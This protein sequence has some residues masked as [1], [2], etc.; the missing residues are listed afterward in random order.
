MSSYGYSAQNTENQ[1]INIDN[2]NIIIN[3]SYW[4]QDGD[5]TCNILYNSGIENEQKYIQ[6]DDSISFN[7]S[8][9]VWNSSYNLNI[10][11]GIIQDV[12]M[13]TGELTISFWKKNTS[14]PSNSDTDILIANGGNVYLKITSTP[15][16]NNKIYCVI[17]DGNG[18]TQN[19]TASTI[20]INF[21]KFN[22]FVYKL[23][24][25]TNSY[26][27]KVFVNGTQV[28]TTSISNIQ[29]ATVD[30]NTIFTFG[31]H[32]SEY[33]DIRIWKHDIAYITPIPVLYYQIYST[34]VSTII[35]QSTNNYNGTITG[36][37][38]NEPAFIY[39][40][41]IVS[42]LSG[43]S[44]SYINISSSV[45]SKLK[46][47]DGFTISYWKYHQSS[48]DN[49]VSEMYTDTNFLKI[50]PSKVSIL[51]TELNN[52]FSFELATWYNIT[53]SCIYNTNSTLE[54]CLYVNGK[55]VSQTVN[56]ING[57][58]DSNISYLRLGSNGTR[59]QEIKFYDKQLSY[60]QVLERHLT[61]LKYG[62]QEHKTQYQ[63]FKF[64]GTLSN[65]ITNKTIP[66][67]F[68][69]PG[70][71]ANIAMWWRF[72]TTS[73]NNY[74][75]LSGLNGTSSG[76]NVVSGIQSAKAGSS[77]T[78]STV[79]TNGTLFNET[80]TQFA[81]SFW[82]KGDTFQITGL[83]MIIKLENN[84]LSFA[85]KIDD[86]E[87]P[88]ITA[89]V[90]NYQD[91]STWHFYTF[92]FNDGI[93]IKIFDN[94]ILLAQAR[95][96]HSKR[97]SSSETS[98]V[99]TP[100]LIQDFRIY[101]SE[102]DHRS[103]ANSMQNVNGSSNTSLYVRYDF[104]TNYEES[105]NTKYLNVID[106]SFDLD[107]R[108]SS[109]TPSIVDGYSG[110]KALSFSNNAQLKLDKPSSITD[111]L[112]KIS[113]GMTISFWSK[114]YM[115]IAFTDTSTNSALLK[116]NLTNSVMR[117]DIGGA[118]VQCNV[119]DTEWHNWV[120][121]YNISRNGTI[122]T[123]LI[124]YMDGV[125]VKDT[126]DED[127]LIFLNSYQENIEFTVGGDSVSNGIIEDLR[128]YSTGLSFHEVQE[129]FYEFNEFKDNFKELFIWYRFYN[130]NNIASINS[131]Y[132]AVI[133][134]SGITQ[135]REGRHYIYKWSSNATGKLTLTDNTHQV[136]S[137]TISLDSNGSYTSNADIVLTRGRKHTITYPSAKPIKISGTGVW[138]EALDEFW[139]EY[140]NNTVSINLPYI[141][142]TYNTL[143]Y[144]CENDQSMGVNAISLLEPE[145]SIYSALQ[146]MV[147]NNMTIAY[148]CKTASKIDINLEN[149]PI[150][151]IQTGNDSAVFRIGIGTGE[152]VGKETIS[153][154]TD[155]DWHHW[156]FILDD[157]TVSTP[158]T[159]ILK[160]YRDAVLV[161]QDTIVEFE[162]FSSIVYSEILN[163]YIGTPNCTLKDFRIY[164][165]HLSE[166]DIYLLCNYHSFDQGLGIN[167]ID[168]LHNPYA[169]H[170]STA[171]KNTQIE[172]PSN[173]LNLCK[174]SIQS[175]ITV[176]IY[177]KSS[178]FEFKFEI[179]TDLLLHVNSTTST[180]LIGT[181]KCT[182]FDNSLN[183]G[184]NKWYR[185]QVSV[186][187]YNQYIQLDSS[188]V[189]TNNVEL[190]RNISNQF[191]TSVIF[192]KSA[193]AK[194]SLIKNCIVDNFKISGPNN[195][196]LLD[197]HFDTLDNSTIVN[198]SSSH[199]NATINE[200]ID[201]NVNLSTTSYS[202]GF[203]L[204]AGASGLSATIVTNDGK[205]DLLLSMQSVQMTLAFWKNDLDVYKGSTD[206]LCYND[207]NEII[208]IVAPNET[209]SVEFHVSNED[210]TTIVKSED[211]KILPNTWYFYT[212]VINF[213][214]LSTTVSV[215]IDA[216]LVSEKVLNGYV[217]F[218]GLTPTGTSLGG[219]P[220]KNESTSPS[221]IEDFRIY[222]TALEV[223]EIYR[224][225]FVNNVVTTT[226][227]NVLFR[228]QDLDN[229]KNLGRL[230]DNIKV[231]KYDTSGTVINNAL[232]TYYSGNNYHQY[233]FNNKSIYWKN[234]TGNEYLEMDGERLIEDFNNTNRIVVMFKQKMNGMRRGMSNNFFTI[235]DYDDNQRV[236]MSILIPDNEQYM[237]VNIGEH[238]LKLNISSN[239]D[240]N[241]W[242][243]WI[244]SINTKN[245]YTYVKIYKDGNP[246]PG[247]RKTFVNTSGNPLQ[248]LPGDR[249][250]ARIGP[251]SSEVYI[252][253][254]RIYNRLITYSDIPLVSNPAVHVSDQ[255][256]YLS[257]NDYTYDLNTVFSGV[258]ISY[259]I[260]SDPLNSAR[261]DNG[262][263]AKIFGNY[264]GQTYDVVFKAYNREGFSLWTVTVEEVNAPPI[265][266]SLPEASATLEIQGDISE[267]GTEGTEQY[268]NFVS[269]IEND[270][271]TALDY[272]AENITIDNITSGSIL[273][274]F[275]VK[276]HPKKKDISPAQ[277]IAS[278]SEEGSPANLRFKNGK[279]TRR[280]NMRIPPGI[281]KQ[282]I[283]PNTIFL[284]LENDKP[285]IF[286]LT[287][288]FSGINVNYQVRD[289][290]YDN[291]IIDKKEQTM[292]I[293]SGFRDDDYIIT[294]R[295]INPSSIKTLLFNITELPQADPVAKDPIN[296][297][298]GDESETVDILEFFIGQSLNQ[299]EIE[300]NPHNNV[301]LVESSV[302]KQIYRIQG[303]FRNDTYEVKFK[304]TQTGVSYPK[305][306]TW[307]LNVY[308]LPPI[309]TK[310]IPDIGSLVL[311]T[312]QNVEYD[313]T[314]VFSGVSMVYEFGCN[315]YGATIT[316]TT[317]SIN[318]NSRGVS[319]PIQVIGKND[320]KTLYWNIN[321]SESMPPPPTTIELNKQI[322]LSTDTYSF[323]LSD[324]FDGT[325]LEYDISQYYRNPTE[326]PPYILPPEHE[327]L[328]NNPPWAR[329]HGSNWDRTF[330]P[331]TSQNSVG[332][333]ELTE[334]NIAERIQKIGGSEVPI[335]FIY[336]DKKATATIPM[337]GGSNWTIC[338]CVKYNGNNKGT[339]ITGNDLIIGHWN[340]N[341]GVVQVGNNFI[342]NVASIGTDTDWLVVCVRTNGT[343]PNNVLLDNS[344]SGTAT[345][346]TTVDKLYINQN[347]SSDWALSDIMIWD[348]ELNSADMSSISNIFVDYLKGKSKILREDKRTLN[349]A[350]IY[351]NVSIDTSSNIVSVSGYYR[352]VSY[353]VYITAKNIKDETTWTLT[354]T[355]LP[356]PPPV[357]IS[358]KTLNLTTVDETFAITNVVSG[359]NI[360]YTI[361]D[362]TTAIEGV[363]YSVIDNIIT[364]TPSYNDTSYSLVVEGS[365]MTSSKIVTFDITETDPQPPQVM[366][367][368]FYLIE[369]DNQLIENIFDNV[370]SANI[371]DNNDIT[372]NN[373]QITVNKA[374]IPFYSVSVES[375]NE[376]GTKQQK[377]NFIEPI[378]NTTLVPGLNTPSFTIYIDSDY[379]DF[380]LSD[381]KIAE[382]YNI[383]YNPYESENNLE[384]VD[385]IL[386]IKD[387]RRGVYDIL[388]KLD[389]YLYVL[390]VN[391]RIQVNLEDR[392]IVNL[393]FD[394]F[395][396]NNTVIPNI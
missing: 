218:K 167:R 26:K 33:Q 175:V 312:G 143:Y 68:I 121:I 369:T 286:D 187:Q 201:P 254:F 342:T 247:G 101:I 344:S 265:Q 105:V 179:D 52:P 225:Y 222:N 205:Q 348:S 109:G 158:G 124:I 170:F 115:N 102:L 119:P 171:G 134:G 24:Y 67:S 21:N 83:D 352:G 289:N 276:P 386:T 61:V 373:N 264:R 185:V 328:I 11:T 51:D 209:G 346:S 231:I 339:I 217:P 106:N 381:L 194:L 271:T 273:V 91:N 321:V 338:T 34:D 190:S 317:M 182:I 371:V 378:Y 178:N 395:T 110:Y 260:H 116:I 256:V 226:D 380:N 246:L 221:Y 345:G 54:I 94:N 153:L 230:L 291:V 211:N 31:S 149:N 304:A 128:I 14:T 311:S 310:L 191:Y 75:S 172:I 306:A 324:I 258:N 314:T 97:V 237:V 302:N 280:A 285:N 40:E 161:N 144:Y 17:G 71:Q 195:R 181:D 288:Y 127:N 229:I 130:N 16:D 7:N 307:T 274:D 183:L 77:G 379:A 120:F 27:L 358:D 292:S 142:Y 150:I 382:T 296:M 356:P 15:Y 162:G 180:F 35:D 227:A 65:Y 235:K 25:T 361:K 393:Q 316:D 224:L 335:N 284:T 337:P 320:S 20:G 283:D 359:Y 383:V 257:G 47:T 262:H 103:I 72:D 329:F 166:N 253:D 13:N 137:Y 299:F 207:T 69:Y 80:F 232:G 303:A 372:Y 293:E 357:S 184:I 322:T 163:W 4:F 365:N 351:N 70:E 343:T 279:Y 122:G 118:T 23:T 240:Y 203:S 241:T 327:V 168:G 30:T 44:N 57:L 112:N 19:L 81:I 85:V 5:N 58:S 136:L 210:S 330:L 233:R 309:P 78:I 391:E 100:T 177:P 138:G 155:N 10:D 160:T 364:L 117:F 8:K 300:L 6:V 156:A 132:G 259:D 55:K 394:S 267:V 193:I 244:F 186:I 251:F 353:D 188:I 108:V 174:Q 92:C 392:L 169:L 48:I 325:N 39:S 53:V 28:G 157:T 213:D 236:I 315:I 252:E 41:P 126:L 129:Q 269:D 347:K 56:K 87:V 374:N 104:I 331:N 159:V 212:F 377:L 82:H 114:T 298:L 390:R 278:L 268:D 95:S 84:E 354:V 60:E 66:I 242:I 389:T 350:K 239:I 202:D 384:I 308:E 133:E 107:L 248:L 18:T 148:W 164:L 363:H 123:N 3:P 37:M 243:S 396:N 140:T 96:N 88:Y 208:K 36:T 277:L 145:P 45:K 263:I 319:Y 165:K 2:D 295:A 43:N 63:D 214:G 313:L 220:R 79:D 287:K 42:K 89:T 204:Y 9:I 332:N 387:R 272:D 199:F 1:N 198:K 29:L 141:Y 341:R 125:M 250:K 367:T 281:A 370:V 385:N 49:D 355:E 261:I 270:L 12:F 388:L 90:E 74:G 336:G 176:W 334:G 113:S 197:Y 340:G 192:D 32:Q 275:T 64:D 99:I 196:T 173:F 349:I 152:Q 238:E 249:P 282:A 22:H 376:N 154:S 223:N 46:I 62:D 135:E 73:P 139:I 206:F 98:I 234:P 219:D 189:D 216:V 305:S 290:P 151:N 131:D 50:K 147:S 318:E 266:E 297:V 301:T 362:E 368:E 76:M 59:F 111:L 255:E 294:L 86:T 93:T 366:N 146:T 228:F 215:Y 200:T 375:T 360:T 38:T 326:D 245:S 323:D 333:I